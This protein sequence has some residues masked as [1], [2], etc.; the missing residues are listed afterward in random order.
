LS[1]LDRLKEAAYTSPSGTR[2]T[3]QYAD[4]SSEVEKRTAAFEFPG[5][6]GAYVQ[7]NGAGARRFPMVC[8]FSGPDC[9]LQAS[10]FED[11]LLERGPGRLDHPLYGRKNVV[12]FGSITRRDDLVT[13]ANQTVLE[14]VFWSTVGAVYP[15]LGLSPKHELSLKIGNAKSALAGGFARKANLLS[16]ARQANAKL[17][18]TQALRNVQGALG[19][20]AAATDSIN[21]EFRDLQQQVNFGLD[22][23]I[24]TPLLLAQQILDLASLPGRAL[25]GI[26]SRLQAYADLLDRMIGSSRSSAGDTSVLPALRIRLANEFHIADLFAGGAVIGSLTSVGNNTFAAKPEALEAAEAIIEQADALT[27]WQDERFGDL[28]QVDTGEGYQALQDAVALAVGFLVEISFSL[29]PERSIILDRPR[30]IVE[31]AAELYGAVDS[32]LDFLISTNKLTGS[33]IIEIPRGRRI[34][35]YA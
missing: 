8:F 1:W 15:S 20:V 35:Y 33:G 28:E 31:L 6:D 5:V 29:V 9:D 23:L 13:A 30:N 14:V 24:G 3:F 11:L 7:D 22:V 2:Q 16:V 19:S 10:A 34:V 17:T 27:A 12:P 21:R 26:A 25:A 4:V 32:R 18:V